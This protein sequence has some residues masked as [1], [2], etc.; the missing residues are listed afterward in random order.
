[1]PQPRPGWPIAWMLLF[2]VLAAVAL[3]Q[4]EAAWLGAFC[5]YLFGRLRQV[6]Q[7]LQL[8]NARLD[9]AQRMAAG[10]DAAPSAAGAAVDGSAPAVGA[11]RPPDPEPESNPDPLPSPRSASMPLGD[12]APAAA[13][14]RRPSL[15]DAGLERLLDWARSGNPLAR[16]G[17]LITFIGAVYL[18]RYAAEEGW[19]PAELRLAGLS[20]AA[21]AMVATGWR[22]RDRV[23]AYALT[24]Q[25][26]GLALLYL[27]VLAALRLYAVLPPTPAFALLVLVAAASAGLAVRQNA[28]PLAIIGFAGGFAA[29]LMIGGDG[30]H[31]LL[32]G[33]YT[34][35]NLGV[36]AV[37]A[38][39]GWGLLNLLGFTFTFVI[40]TLWRAT[41]YRLEW[42]ASAEFFLL[43]FFAMYIAVTVLSARGG[44]RRSVVSGSL[45][46]G[47]PAIVLSLQASLVID[48]PHGLAISAAGFGVF[49]LLVASALLRSGRAH[50]QTTALAFMAIGVVLLSLAV[51]LYWDEQATAA[52]W[53]LEGAGAVWLGLR[54]QRR[55][56]LGFGLLIQLLAGAAQLIAIGDGSAA[57]PSAGRALFAIGVPGAALLAVAGFASGTWLWRARGE[58]LLPRVAAVWALAWWL[59]AGTAQLDQLAPA[60]ATGFDLAFGAISVALLAVAG[61]RLGWFWLL[62]LGEVTALLF[63]LGG[64]A[65]A[66]EHR[67][68]Y[69]G[70][71]LGWLLLLVVH[72]AVLWR[73]ERGAA[74]GAP[75]TPTPSPQSASHVLPAL[76]KVWL[77]GLELAWHLRDQLGGDWPWLAAGIAPA[78]ALAFVA[79]FP[80]SG[81]M[82]GHRPLYARWLAAPLA[83][84]LLGWIVVAALYANGNAAP[85]PTWP[86]LNPLDV[87]VLAVAG[88]LAYAWHRRDSAL[89]PWQLAPGGPPAARHLPAALAAIA[90][91]VWLNGA[92]VRGL[93]YS[94]G[95]PL[96]GAAL[97]DSALLQASVS[98]VWSL[99]GCGVMWIAARRGLRGIWLIGGGLMAV[100]AIKLFAVD[101]AGTGTLARI[102]AFLLVGAILLAAGYFAPLPGSRDGRQS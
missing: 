15:L 5:G 63:A 3:Q 53:A 35:L 44:E 69:Q 57:A 48:Y 39:R 37:A 52:T 95:T 29:P 13:T 97:L 94:C 22:L 23:S 74:P 102:A 16:L 4:V 30:S 98:V 42:F 18:I 40:T 54:Q 62:Q 32:F 19:L 100:V 87:T 2:A 46:F 8:L 82:A 90:A 80:D 79:R 50:W 75:P 91:F 68:S 88:V 73:W 101:T 24:L 10:T 31:L 89:Q 61:L 49:Y 70:G 26:G 81:P 1:M 7:K 84:W 41:A 93:H 20:A 14:A 51:P 59:Y 67:P 9:A 64:L 99:I 11:E 55:W 92:L 83:L 66:L 17:V 47:L 34:V 28:L 27:T 77:G 85:L 58:T 38:A 45:L 71:A 43:L 6:E 78:S 96:K 60:W 21:L 86:L 25:G 72:Y 12:P 65:V 33:Y 76:L 56:T 36:F